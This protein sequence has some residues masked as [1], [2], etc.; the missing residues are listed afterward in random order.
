MIPVKTEDKKVKGVK[1]SLVKKNVTKKD[2]VKTVRDNVIARS[3]K[4]YTIRRFGNNLFVS[5]ISKRILTKF[6]AK[7]LYFD[8]L[9]T[10]KF[11]FCYPLHALT[12]LTKIAEEHK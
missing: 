1:R 8:V 2:F 11:H 12:D 7:R 10:K 5:S 4:Q 6:S 9:A 3:L